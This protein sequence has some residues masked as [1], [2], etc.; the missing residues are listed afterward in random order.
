MHKLLLVYGLVMV[1]IFGAVVW[2]VRA[3]LREERRFLRGHLAQDLNAGRLSRAE[4]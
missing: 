2:L 1:P 3:S 4:A